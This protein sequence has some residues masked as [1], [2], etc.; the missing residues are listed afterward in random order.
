M[1]VYMYPRSSL[2]L[3]AFGVVIQTSFRYTT[4][5]T[6]R[7]VTMTSVRRSGSVPA[8]GHAHDRC[9]HQGPVMHVDPVCTVVVAVVVVV[10]VMVRSKVHKC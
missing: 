6:P 7:N 1:Y 10:V 4:G 2:E 3:G 9:P 8:V 5:Y